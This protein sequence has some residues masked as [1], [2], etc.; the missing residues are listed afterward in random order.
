MAL[1]DSIMS[2]T[3]QLYPKGRAW[4]MPFGGVFEKLNKGL[5][6]S[7]AQMYSDAVSILND[8]IPDNDN[9]TSDDA[10]DWERRLGMITNT[11][12]SLSD[13]KLAIARKMNF[14]GTTVARQT[15]QYLQDQLQAA[16]FNVFVYENRFSNYPN[17]YIT[18]DPVEV[19]GT[20]AIINDLNHG[21]FNHGEQ[22]HGGIYNNLIANSIT[23]TGD[24]GFKTGSNLRSTFF[25]GGNPIGTYANVDVAREIEFRQLILQTKPVQTVGFL[26]INYI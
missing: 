2:L 8:L 13:R 23:Q 11:S 12:I 18:R 26:F 1:T 6:I 19:Y 4:K 25:V 24:I 9:F 17:G 16:G 22:N 15:W 20:T 10:T 7:Q 21:E 14:P 3:R 5:I